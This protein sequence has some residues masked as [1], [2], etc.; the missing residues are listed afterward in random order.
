MA[1]Y[2][3]GSA[4]AA[5]VDAFWV[6]G[7]WMVGCL[8]VLGV[9][10]YACNTLAQQFGEAFLNG[11]GSWGGL[12]RRGKKARQKGVSGAAVWCGASVSNAGQQG[13]QGAMLAGCAILASTRPNR[14]HRDGRTGQLES[15]GNTGEKSKT[16]GRGRVHSPSGAPLRQW[17][18]A[19][20]GGVQ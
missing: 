4:S 13:Q 1:K 9:C 12:E 19:P 18:R 10:M 16:R 14:E 5:C 11:G 7:G 3:Q 15:R 8:R 2:V 6:P 20:R 17:E